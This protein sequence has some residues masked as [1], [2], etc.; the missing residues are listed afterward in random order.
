MHPPVTLIIV[1]WN[2]LEKTLACL[3][4]V[5]DLTYPHLNTILVDNGSD[6]PLAGAIAERFPAVEILRLPRNTGFAGGY[7]A[8]LRRAL[9]GQSDYFLLL[10]NDTELAADVIEHLVAEMATAPDV[11]LVTAKIYY[12]DEPDRIWTVGNNL[13]VFLDL[14]DGGENEIDRGQW[15][16]A[17][18][19]D[20]AP[21]CGILIRRAVIER[22][23]F[24]DEGFFL[25]YEDMD[26]CRRAQ[27]AGYRLR[28]CPDAHIR[29]AVSASTG[30]LETA[31]KRYWLAQSSGRYFRKHGRGA[32]MA[33]IIP[34]RLASA[35]KTTARLLLSGRGDV[36]K[37]Y[38]AGLVAGWRSGEA[39]TPPP[40]W[41]RT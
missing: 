35:I 29:H 36:A 17:R 1:A 25:Y 37:A 12:A 28:L 7:N 10:N 8:G 32:R 23:G 6:P 15:S 14:K 39:T 3:E 33:L 16:E 31:I 21:F 2:Q 24:L 18:D 20:F 11:G 13:N 19:I 34:F 40:E 9:E 26:Y 4:S 22:V 41:I 27:L 30:G 5:A 38:W